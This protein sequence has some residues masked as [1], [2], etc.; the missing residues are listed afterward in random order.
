MNLH[1]R[2]LIGYYTLV[3]FLV[4]CAVGAALGFNHLAEEVA[5]GG[6]GRGQQ[7]Q[8]TLAVLAKL[9]NHDALLRRALRGDLESRAELPKGWSDLEN[10]V[11]GSPGKGVEPSPEQSEVAWAMAHYREV[12]DQLLAAP[13]LEANEEPV[14][15]ALRTVKG[16]L[17]QAF[18]SELKATVRR[19]NDVEIRAR[20]YATVYATLL[21][22]SLIVIAF[23][24]RQLRR[25]LVDRLVATA[26]VA[27]AV[28]D[29]DRSRRAVVGGDDELGIIADQLNMLLDTELALHAEMEGRLGQQ[30]QLLLGLADAWPKKVAIYTIYGDLAVSTLAVEDHE[31][32]QA[33][34][35]VFPD[36]PGK[37]EEDR[38][39]TAT[40]GSREL[41]FRLLR[42]GGRRPVGWLTELE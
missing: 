7:T 17:Y 10:A 22:I 33:A 14:V 25:G 8:T 1:L 34:E 30:R 4:V 2:V 36:P 24:S 13:A 23:L 12:S 15:D 6:A 39:F 18:E 20:R 19:E 11:A 3:G 27:E 31:A 26:S 32:M 40:V 21:V 28:A 38:D 35:I 29:G 42:A 41:T 9:D 37:P 5:Q 16:H